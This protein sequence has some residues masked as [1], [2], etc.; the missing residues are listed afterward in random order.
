MTEAEHKRIVKEVVQEVLSILASNQQ[1]EEDRLFA[2]E[3]EIEN[4]V[5]NYN[6][7]QD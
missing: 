2:I 3:E 1:S 6:N 4:A 5:F 7:G